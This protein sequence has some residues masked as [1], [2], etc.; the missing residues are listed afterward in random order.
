MHPDLEETDGTES[1]LSTKRTQIASPGE[2]EKMR[3]LQQ[4]SSRKRTNAVGSLHSTFY[5]EEVQS[6]SS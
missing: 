2:W 3:I 1:D 5:G 4:S 6:V